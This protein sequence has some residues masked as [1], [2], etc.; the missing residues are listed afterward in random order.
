MFT[1][2]PFGTAPGVSEPKLIVSAPNANIGNNRIRITFF[3][4]HLLIGAMPPAFARRTIE[5]CARS[6][7]GSLLYDNYASV[8]LVHADFGALLTLFDHSNE[9][10]PPFR[11]E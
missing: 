6:L 5:M 3:I 2:H 9:K 11:H 1:D 10:F 8:R 4:D 7:I